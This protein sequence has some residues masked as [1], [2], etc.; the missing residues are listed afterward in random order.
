MAIR[1]CAPRRGSKARELLPEFRKSVPLRSPIVATAAIR[2][3]LAQMMAATA[4]VA[5]FAAGCGQ[6]PQVLTDEA[7]RNII[8][9]NAELLDEAVDDGSSLSIDG[10]RT[11]LRTFAPTPPAEVSDVLAVLVAEGES[12]GWLFTDRSATLAVGTKEIDGRPWMVSVGV[13]DDTV[14]QLFAGR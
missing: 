14:Q 8:P 12:D 10:E 13:S 11:V 3:R 5:A 7:F 6:S 4:I 1:S 2:R 9:A